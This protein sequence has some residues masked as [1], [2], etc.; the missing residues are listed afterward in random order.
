MKWSFSNIAWS[1][2]DD[3]EMYRR[4][5][6]AGFSY[7][8][9][10]PTR[11]LGEQP[12]QQMETAAEW[13][14]NLKHNYGFMV[15]SM[16]SIWYGR[17]EKLF[18]D[19]HQRK[20]LL[21]YTK[22]AILFA[23][24]IGCPHLV[25]GCP[26]NRII[27]DSVDMHIGEAFFEELAAFAES[28]M[29]VIGMEANPSIYGTNYINTTQQ[30][31]DLIRKINQKG[32][33]LNLDTGTMIANHES[34]EIIK[35][36][37]DLISHVHISEPFLKQIEKRKLHRDILDILRDEGYNGCVS[38]EMGN[39]GDLQAVQNVIKY[40]CEMMDERAGE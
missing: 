5:A 3:E 28:H 11:I 15:S 25:F 23:E 14:R 31:L 35:G 10:A 13:S 12:Y 2:E 40:V 30:A 24:K 27:P 37:V 19:V 22:D 29:T 39:S 1:A 4:L 34:A 6:E 8:E 21:E 9:I 38:V 26:K 17:T 16:Q 7:I 20:V 33:R 18:A 36:S 32:F